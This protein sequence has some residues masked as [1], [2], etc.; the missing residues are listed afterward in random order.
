MKIPQIHTKDNKTYKFIKKIN[1][2]IFLYEEINYKF[3]E[4]F[5]KFDLNLIE[6]N[7]KGADKK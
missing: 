7:K 1:D 5:S 6:Y 2:N 4:C 3:K